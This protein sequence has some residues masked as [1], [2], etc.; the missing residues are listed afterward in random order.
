MTACSLRRYLPKFVRNMGKRLPHCTAS[1]PRSQHLEELSVSRSLSTRA[2][3]MYVSSTSSG[4]TASHFRC[5][6][7]SVSTHSHLR[8]CVQCSLASV[9]DCGNYEMSFLFLSFSSFVS[10]FRLSAF[11]C[12]FL[13]SFPLSFVFLFCFVSPSF[14]VS[15]LFHFFIFPFFFISS[16]YYFLALLSVYISF[17]FFLFP[18]PFSVFFFL[19]F[20]SFFLSAFFFL[21]LFLSF[22]FLCLSF[23]F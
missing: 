18:F 4:L 19:Y 21:C 15:F 17:V 1:Q 11:F 6:R 5:L 2:S 8:V 12:L 13:P 20:P 22:I 14:I 10:F 23:C 9:D 3:A 16:S 7:A